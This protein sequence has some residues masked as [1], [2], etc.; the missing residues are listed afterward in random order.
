VGEAASKGAD[1]Q[2]GAEEEENQQ[3]LLVFKKKHLVTAGG[4]SNH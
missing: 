1:R 4:L 2:V 3:A